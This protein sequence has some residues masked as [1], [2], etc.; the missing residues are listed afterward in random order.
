MPTEQTSQ[1]TVAE[2]HVAANRLER[3]ITELRAVESIGLQE[4]WVFRKRSLD[5]AIERAESFHQELRRAV[6]SI[7]IGD[8]IGP[9][10]EKGRHVNRRNNAVAAVSDPDIHADAKAY[11]AKASAK[12]EATPTK[13]RKT[14]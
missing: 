7:A 5:I 8:P 1:L 12:K 13:R 9:K 4:I 14:S 10:T 11:A 6:E 3:L 2:C